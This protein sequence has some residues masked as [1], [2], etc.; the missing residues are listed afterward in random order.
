MG[1]RDDLREHNLFDTNDTAIDADVAAG[2]AVALRGGALG[3]RVVQ[4]PVRTRHGHGEDPVRA[5]RA[6]R[7][8]RAG[9]PGARPHPQPPAGQHAAAGAWAGDD[10][11]PHAQRA[12]RGVA[13]VRDPRL[14]QPRH[15]RDALLRGAPPA[16]R[17]LADRPDDAAAHPARPARGRHLRQHRDPLVGRIPDLRQHAGVPGRR[18]PPGAGQGKGRDRA[19][20]PDRHRPGAA[21]QLRRP[22]RLVGRPGA[23]AHAV[24]ARAQRRLRHARRGLPLLVG[25]RG[26]RQG[27]AGRRRAHRQD[28][29]GRVDHRD[30]Q[31]ARA[32]DRHADQLV[33]PRRGA[34]P[35]ALRPADRRR[36]AQRHPRVAHRPPLRPVLDH[37]GVRRGLPHAPAH[38]RR[39]GAALRGRPAD[40]HSAAVHGRRAAAAAG[41]CCSSTA[42]RTCCTRWARPTPAR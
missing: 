3:G 27:P 15:G 1:I 33:R 2:A 16:G 5:Q 39:T 12:R 26:V 29:H 36:G 42:R 19:G 35:P 20:R 18:A 13:A 30:P 9:G 28:P 10:P 24:H 17:R 8:H 6:A 11:R 7:R 23:A 37:R 4:R 14:V 40:Q 25:R 38:P 31:P 22:R 34:R 32:A 41:R 21:R